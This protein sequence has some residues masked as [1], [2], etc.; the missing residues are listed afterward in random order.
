MKDS[1]T[2]DNQPARS[3]WGLGKRLLG[4]RVD[5]RGGFISP[6]GW[7]RTMDLAGLEVLKLSR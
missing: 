4:A 6:E 5:S 7:G 2:K 1:T 3:G